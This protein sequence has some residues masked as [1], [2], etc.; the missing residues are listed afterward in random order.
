MPPN[1]LS[2]ALTVPAQMGTAL[3]RCNAAPR[4]ASLVITLLL[5]LS[6]VTG[7]WAAAAKT[8]AAPEVVAARVTTTPERARVILDLSGATKFAILSLDNPARIAV[9]L[10]AQD[11]KFD[12]APAPA[13]SGLVTAF[14]VTMGDPGKARALVTL[15]G[16][17]QVQQAYVLDAF[18]DQPARLVVDLSPDTQEAFAKRVAV[19]AAASPAP[20]TPATSAAL[21]QPAGAPG[22]APTATATDSGSAPIVDA[23]PSST[24][25]GAA[26]G[27][28]AVAPAAA[29]VTSI[30]P[31]TASTAA[32][33]R[34]LIVLDPGHGGVDNG[35][36]APNGVH[37]KNI[38]LAFALKLQNLLVQS[39]KFDV[40]LTRTDDEYLTL[41]QRVALGRQNKADLFISIHADTFGQRD[42]HGTSIYTRDEQ[43][44]DVLDKVLAENENKTDIV[45]GFAVPRMTPQI[46]DVLLDLLRRQMRKQSYLAADSI[47]RALQPSFELRRFP[48]RQADF[49]VLQAPDV[50]SM[51]IELGFLSNADDIANLT[52]PQWEDRAA[53][54]I[55]HGISNYFDAAATAP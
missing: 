14:S 55:A 21:P 2:S 18:G 27:Q 22:Q 30:A 39:G 15:A 25:Q 19:D 46:V 35:A 10:R 8:A 1:R 49:F 9:D 26:T 36:T 53:A 28:A 41:E 13:G 31:A 33:G 16:P 17:A 50:P 23:A 34:P 47:I 20:T 6:V 38:T 42:I 5:L 11:L 52:N 4:I 32:K 51:L 44:T 7:A 43:A 40:A 45:A 3:P 54:A 29:P 24:D 12:A 37:E 48:V